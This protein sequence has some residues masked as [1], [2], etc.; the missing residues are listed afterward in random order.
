MDIT[1]DAL[2]FIYNLFILGFI[3]C[4]YSCKKYRK[5][6]NASGSSMYQDNEKMEKKTSVRKH[7]SLSLTILDYVSTK[8]VP[9]LRRLNFHTLFCQ[10]SVSFLRSFALRTNDGIHIDRKILRDMIR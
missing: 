7:F 9:F 6:K 5:R 1:S 2:L 8:V 10:H 3:A 4:R